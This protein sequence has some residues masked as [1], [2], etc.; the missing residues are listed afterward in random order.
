V[1]DVKE[2]YLLAYKLGCKGITVY[3]D[4]S[5]DVQVLN[6]GEKVKQAKQKGPRPRPTFTV[7]MTEKVKTGDG[8]LYVT[9]N[10][11]DSGLCE[12]FTNIGKAGG[13]AA[14]QSEAI[15][16]LISLALRSGVDVKSVIKQLKGISGPSPV[17]D[18]GDLILS[19][20]DAI[21]KAIERYMKR[22]ETPDLFTEKLTEGL[23]QSME[24]EAADQKMKRLMESRGNICA[25]CGSIMI[26]EEGCMKC[27]HCGF[28]KCY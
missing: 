5:R 10:E 2:A 9:I 21:A 7:G 20:P 17:W 8:T 1:D 13:N 3:R 26:F 6:V 12:V 24:E 27:Y 25:E 16:R 23:R 19:G 18:D 4:G 28:S 22:K 15:S 11:D 14:A